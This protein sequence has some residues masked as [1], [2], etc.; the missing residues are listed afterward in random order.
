[1]VVLCLAVWS[2]A[3][4]PGV[5]PAGTTTV[6]VT[7]TTVPT[8]TTSGGRISRVAVGVGSHA[9]P[10]TLNPFL[11]GPDTAI[12]DLIGPAFF[13]A[14][15]DIDPET[16]QPVPDV[17]ATI[18]TL[19]N[20]GLT[21][22]PNGTMDV[23]VGVNPGAVWADG[24]R[25]T[26]A[27]LAFTIETVT[28]PA[29]PIR[30]DLRSR[31]ARIVPG[32][33]R[34]SGLELRFRMDIHP[35]VELLFDLIL[36][37]HAVAGSDFVN[38][39]ND[40]TW[41]SG[42]PFEVESYQPGQYLALSRNDLYWKV[43][44]AT[45][46]RLPYFDSMVVR[47]FDP[48][49]SEDPRLFRAFQAR[50]LDVAVMDFSQDGAG[51]YLEL[52]REGARLIA[53]PGMV[54]EQINFQFGPGNRNGES[55]NQ[56]PRY[57]RAVM[58]AIDRVALAE[59]SGTVP[60]SSALR[61][62]LPHLAD[63]PWAVYDYDDEETAGLL[64]NLGEDI[65]QD[66]F[67]GGGP[68]LVI[69]TSSDSTGTVAMAGALVVMLNEAGIGAELQL[70][71]PS[72]FFGQTLDNG[73]WDV[74][75]WRFEGS[76]GRSGA[77]AFIELFDPEGLPFIG[78][79]FFRWG[80]VDSLVA[81]SSTMRYAQIVDEIRATI[82]PAEIDRLLLEAEGLLAS[83]AVLLPLLVHERSGAAVWMDRVTGVTA[84]PAQ[85]ELWDVETWRPPAG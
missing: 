80:T 12:L 30:S 32:S 22:N 23:A 43:D 64:F 58:H 53:A 78:S 59:R 49:D 18:P 61:I 63:D 65:G 36:P 73:T 47:F 52:E 75:A 62:Y 50:D 25:I 54:W 71:D 34:A 31:Y 69:T 20:G 84:N 7:S 60:L 81:D 6:P 57:R 27:D 46:G 82:D 79:N 9:A 17:L 44:A 77:I 5:A 15:Y 37:A 74:A 55:L 40:R 10:R 38:D 14:G 56:F 76:P 21:T 13:A 1:V 66:L 72:L 67:A 29:L 4:A 24:T 68:R 39:W 11:D 3:P 41:V 19:A 2:C 85:S 26:A 83:Q 45:G 42:G 16:R 70:E 8:A 35:D 48:A 33:V 51:D 28:D